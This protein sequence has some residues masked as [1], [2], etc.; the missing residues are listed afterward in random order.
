MV[1]ISCFFS[2]FFSCFWISKAYTQLISHLS[3][4]QSCWAGRADVCA[5]APSFW[6]RGSDSASSLLSITQ[7]QRAV[8][9]PFTKVSSSPS[10]GFFP[11]MVCLYVARKPQ[12]PEVNRV[13]VK[14]RSSIQDTWPNSKF[15]GSE[16]DRSEGIT[17]TSL[18]PH[19]LQHARPPCPSPSP[20]V[21]TNSCPLSQWCHPT[22]SSSV[23]P[24][25]SRLQSFPESGSFPMS[26][27]FASGGQSIGASALVVVLSRKIQGLY[28]LG[29]TGLISLQSK[30]LSRVFSSSTV[31]KHQFF[32]VQPSLW[33][34]SHIFTRLLEKP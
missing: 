30:G 32:S 25:S 20:R 8:L 11:S 33:Y 22:I 12:Q 29:L 18:R 28:P 34:H 27:P 10:Y 3:L 14:V 15:T 26:Q 21:C 16:A 6:E 5:S 1:I 2:F 7:V 23:T 4:K 19:G 24:F 17:F 13:T 31:Q 9:R